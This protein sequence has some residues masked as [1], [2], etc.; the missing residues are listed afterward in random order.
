MHFWRAY[1]HM[2]TNRCFV[3]S[4]AQKGLP[5][6]A[7]LDWILI[8]TKLLE[9]VC[10][11]YWARQVSS[12]RVRRQCLR[13]QALL[14][15]LGCLRIPEPPDALELEIL[16]GRLSLLIRLLRVPTSR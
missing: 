16:F 4:T 9:V 2:L 3:E 6:C 10:T 13:T 12:L 1:Y 7:A 15:T 14:L 8:E 5:G 11:N